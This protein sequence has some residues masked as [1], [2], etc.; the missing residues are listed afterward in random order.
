[1]PTGSFGSLA[2][3][4]DSSAD[5]SSR[6]QLFLRFARQLDRR[7]APRSADR[8]S[9]TP[10]LAQDASP[11]ARDQSVTDATA[12][13]NG[14][15]ITSWT[16]SRAGLFA[17]FA[18][19]FSQLRDRWFAHRAMRIVQRVL[20]DSLVSRGGPL[21]GSLYSLGGS[22]DSSTDGSRVALGGSLNACSIAQSF[23]T[24]DRSFHSRY[25]HVCEF[26]GNLICPILYCDSGVTVHS[27]PVSQPPGPWTDRSSLLLAHHATRHIMLF[28]LLPIPCPLGFSCG[29]I[30]LCSD[31]L[32]RI[33]STHSSCW[34]TSTM[35]STPASRISSRG[36]TL[37]MRSRGENY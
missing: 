7:L 9:R 18:R 31:L 10:V 12:C 37:S 5:R 21:D 22:L 32:T 29:V 20:D 34:I 8:S 28:F 4:L 6:A 23:R 16:I 3:S 1:V 14:L 27:T 13:H 30:S 2:G 35:G 17:Q 33:F 19:R 25:P 24:G 15:R 11:P 36:E 26:L